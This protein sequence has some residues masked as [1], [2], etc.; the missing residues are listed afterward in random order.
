VQQTCAKEKRRRGLLPDA[1]EVSFLRE[2]RR[3]TEG[4]GEMPEDQDRWF[5]VARDE[6]RF[7]P[8]IVF[9]IACKPVEACSLLR[10]LSLRPA[11]ALRGSPEPA[12]FGRSSILPRRV[13]ARVTRSPAER[14][15]KTDSGVDYFFFRRFVF[16]GAFFAAA[17]VF[18]F[19]AI[20][21]L[22]V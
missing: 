18:R 22:L 10:S 15:P 4:V 2:L 19:F 5:L 14:V 6:A 11:D 7:F 3:R 13:P 1:A 16:F 17:L 20:A 9:A 21:A 8:A 12:R